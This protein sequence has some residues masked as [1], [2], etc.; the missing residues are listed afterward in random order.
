MEVAV[1]FITSD[2]ELFREAHIMNMINS[3]K[4]KN[5][6]IQLKIGFRIQG[7]FCRN[8]NSGKIVKLNKPWNYLFPIFPLYP[9]LLLQFGKILE[10]WL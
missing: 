4:Q 3:G 2:L 8:R 7:K 10:G 5:L 6:K 9:I 1:A